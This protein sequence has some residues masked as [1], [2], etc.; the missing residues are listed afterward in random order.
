MLLEE[1]RRPEATKTAPVAQKFEPTKQQE[2]AK[3]THAQAGLS[4]LAVNDEAG[5]FPLLRRPHGLGY[6][7]QDPSQQ[8][9][10]YRPGHGDGR[11]GLQ[12]HLEELCHPS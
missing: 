3:V 2:L 8:V 9:L 11:E 4:K 7:N 10:H 6:G 12:F 1:F 5:L